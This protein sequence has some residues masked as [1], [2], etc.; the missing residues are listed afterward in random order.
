VLG[1]FGT[2]TIA[3]EEVH[4]AWVDEPRG[5]GAP[6]ISRTRDLLVGRTHQDSVGPKGPVPLQNSP[7]VL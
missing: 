5:H 7:Q 6:W 3:P 4:R 1:W 2:V